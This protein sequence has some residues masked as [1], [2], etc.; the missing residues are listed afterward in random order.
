MSDPRSVLESESRR[1]I[2]ADGAFERLAY[3][4]DR[5]RRNQRIQAGMLGLTIAIAG[6]WLGVNAIRSTPYVPAKEPTLT[7]TPT[8]PSVVWSPV[9]EGVALAVHHGSTWWDPHDTAVAWVDVEHVRYDEVSTQPSWS[10]ELAARPPLAA[11]LEPGQLIAYGLV[12]DTTGDGVA[13]YVIGID[14]D[15]PKQGDFHVWVTDLATGET[16]EQIGGPYGFPIEFFHPD[17]RGPGDGPSTRTMVFSFFR[18]TAPSDL[19]P[20][21]VRWYAWASAAR[22][23]E[24]VAMDYAPDAGW[25]TRH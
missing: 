21:R 25:M 23:G 12:L 16:D 2:Q 15:A 5:K 1:F 3:R 8:P 7:P 6:A 18:S 10:I 13:D 24:V 14:N 22:G 17:E 19:I 11:N 4:R 20:A 9:R